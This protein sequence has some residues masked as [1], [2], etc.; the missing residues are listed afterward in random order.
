VDP[1]DFQLG[2]VRA[3]LLAALEGSCEIDA[4]RPIQAFDGSQIQRRNPGVSDLALRRTLNSG[5][6]VGS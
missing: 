5:R 3:E 2:G 1:V 4:E 6:L